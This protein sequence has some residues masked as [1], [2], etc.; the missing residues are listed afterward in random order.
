MP[1]TYQILASNTLS[2][3]VASVTFSGI[4]SI[5]TDL[6]LR[7]SART[8]QTSQPT[9]GLRLT[10]NG[11]NT[12]TYNQLQGDGSTA[13]SSPGGASFQLVGNINGPT[14]TANTFSSTEIYIPNYA[15]TAQKQFSSHSA[16]ENNTT[17]A[18]TDV[19]ALLQTPTQAITSITIVPGSA[20]N[21]VSGSSFYLYGIAKS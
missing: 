4:S 9:S 8:D 19:F 1:S 17:S 15:L 6:A 2:A 11:T 21:F 16:Q 13:N 14:S 5:Y 12:S 20:P 7:I 10:F 18:F 3:S